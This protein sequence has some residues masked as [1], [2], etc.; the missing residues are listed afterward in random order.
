MF[1]V[2]IYLVLQLTPSRRYIPHPGT[3]ITPTT[4]TLTPI[5]INVVDNDCNPNPT[6]NDTPWFTFSQSS[7]SFFYFTSLTVAVTNPAR[8]SVSACCCPIKSCIQSRYMFPLETKL[9]TILPSSSSCMFV[10]QTQLGSCRS[11]INTS[12]YMYILR[13]HSPHWQSLLPRQ[14]LEHIRDQLN[15][16]AHH[17][18]HP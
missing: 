18:T 13:L 17:S 10:G 3:T 9:R 8:I 7:F 4:A 2:I 15:T 16:H 12:H 11:H 6:T 14:S 1:D 5:I